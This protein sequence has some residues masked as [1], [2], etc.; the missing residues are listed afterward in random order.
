MES[1]LTFVELKSESLIHKSLSL[2]LQSQIMCHLVIDVLCNT[3]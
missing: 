1:Q 3:T 2:V